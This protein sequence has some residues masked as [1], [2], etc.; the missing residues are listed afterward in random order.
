MMLFAAVP[1]LP[2]VPVP[3]FSS[4]VSSLQGYFS[5]E[6]ELHEITRAD[7]PKIKKQQAIDVVAPDNAKAFE[8]VKL[9]SNESSLSASSNKIAPLVTKPVLEA[10]ENNAEKVDTKA[11]TKD[12]SQVQVFVSEKMPDQN[13]APGDPQLGAPILP[14]IAPTSLKPKSP[15]VGWSTSK[16]VDEPAA[17]NVTPLELAV[18]P[19]LE[20]IDEPVKR[21]AFATA[22]IAQWN[23]WT[24]YFSDIR[25][26]IMGLPPLPAFLW[27]G[28]AI[29]LLLV[30]ATKVARSN[31]LI[32]NSR[33]APPSVVNMVAAAAGQLELKR[34]PLT[35]ITDQPISPML[36]C[37]RRVYLIL[38]RELWTQLDDVGRKA[39][40]YH[41]LAHLHRRD[42]WVCWFEMIIGW[43]Y[44]WNPVVWWVRKRIRE[45]ADG[46]G[47]RNMASVP[48]PSSRVLEWSLIL[49][50]IVLTI[51]IVFTYVQHRSQR[52][53]PTDFN[54]AAFSSGAG[55]APFE[56]RIANPEDVTVRIFIGDE[57]FIERTL[58]ADQN[59]LKIV[60]GEFDVLIRNA[61][62]LPFNI[63]RED[64]GKIMDSGKPIRLVFSRKV[65][66]R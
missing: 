62:D 15:G 14:A 33:L 17:V 42:H 40:I 12:S 26:A 56:L 47:K 44:W 32:K 9:P 21:S 28:G 11:E 7:S 5:T 19:K 16:I 63:G 66:R 8:K 6:A 18:A 53:S 29:I 30:S 34:A 50:A 41:E 61:S 1:V 43:L 31:R 59:I 64:L 51:S 24:A 22:T 2:R 54:T 38:P 20:K 52:S 13:Q 65:N 46:V 36:W 49:G 48:R 10:I 45:E 25:N 27:I 55:A 39:V 58:S 4:I 35:L 3:Q 23:R 60:D 57:E 37:G